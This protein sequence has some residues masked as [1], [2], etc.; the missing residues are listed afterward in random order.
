MNALHIYQQ[1]IFHEPAFIVGSKKSLISLRKAI[2]QAL[3]TGFSTANFFTVDGEGY[4]AHVEM[5]PENQ[6][7]WFAN[8]QL[9][10]TR[11]K[12]F[13]ITNQD[14]NCPWDSDNVKKHYDKLL[15]E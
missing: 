9:P 6:E 1:E 15:K 7:D 11:G 5:I 8:M 4:H 2:D 12:D 10:Y 14:K 13:G 3:A